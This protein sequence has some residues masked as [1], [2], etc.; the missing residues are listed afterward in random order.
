M[1]TGVAAARERVWRALTVPAELVRWDRHLL[2]LLDEAPDYPRVGRAVRWRTRLGSVPLVLHDRP[3]EVVEGERLRSAV[4]LGLFHFDA[5]IALADAPDAPGH[6]RLA[7]RLQA[8]SSV[9][10][11]G[12]ALDRFAVRR[13]ASR[14]VD[15]RLRGLRAW[16][17]DGAVLDAAGEAPLP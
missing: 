1:S 8:E 3:L 10:L 4:A 15:E 6:T 16:C 5:T 12:G 7:L 14:I 2:A 11:V 13:L 9:P 17:E